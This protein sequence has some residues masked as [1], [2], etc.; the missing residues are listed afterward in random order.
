MVNASAEGFKGLR[1]GLRNA[2]LITFFDH[3][4]TPMPEASILLNFPVTG[5]NSLS[6]IVCLVLLTAA[7]LALCLINKRVRMNMTAVD[8]TTAFSEHH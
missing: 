3:L 4:D 5:I 1:K 2:F 8:F 6:K 7:G